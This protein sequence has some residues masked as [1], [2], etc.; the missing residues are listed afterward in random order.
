M[1]APQTLPKLLAIFVITDTAIFSNTDTE[2]RTNIKNCRILISTRITDT[3]PALLL[4]IWN[5]IISHN[6]QDRNESQSESV[7]CKFKVK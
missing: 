7:W 1:K 4:Y 5:E 2:Y 3:D 6:F